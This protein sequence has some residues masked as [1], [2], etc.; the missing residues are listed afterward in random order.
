MRPVVFYSAPGMT[1]PFYH[2]GY[3]GGDSMNGGASQRINVG[4]SASRS[5]AIYG[6]SSTVTPLSRKTTFVIKY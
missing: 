1:G 6:A 2:N 5:N 4:F 3:E